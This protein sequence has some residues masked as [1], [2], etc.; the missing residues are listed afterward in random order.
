MLCGGLQACESENVIIG[1]LG[2]HSVQKIVDC[3]VQ[4]PGEHLCIDT[5][6]SSDWLEL[7]VS[8]WPFSKMAM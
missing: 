5:L 1:L 4:I 7:G 2:S 3:G 8:G 6:M